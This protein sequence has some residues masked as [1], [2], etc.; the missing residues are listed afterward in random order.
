MSLAEDDHS[1]AR[2]REPYRV[3]N[4]GTAIADLGHLGSFWPG[5]AVGARERCSPDG[6]GILGA[7]V[8]VSDDENISAAGSDL[9]HQRP[10][11]PIPV[12]ATAEDG[13]QSALGDLTKG[14]QRCRDGIG[15]VRVID[16]GKKRL[17]GVDTFHPARYAWA[18]ADSGG[19]LL[20][21]DARGRQRDDREQRILE[22]V[23]A[24]HAHLNRH[25]HPARADCGQGTL[26][27]PQ[28]SVRPTPVSSPPARRRDG[29]NRDLGLGC[30][31]AAVVVVD[32]DHAMTSP[33]RSEQRPFGGEV[34]LHIAVEIEMVLAEVGEGSDVVQHAVDAAEGQ[35]VARDLHHG[36]SHAALAHHREERVQVC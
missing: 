31:P 29:H 3:G 16:H 22:V 19:R 11:S 17:A 20:D 13:N 10:L 12:A 24:G 26:A 28:D 25:A 32:V 8:V 33:L 21:R 14:G 5:D 9:P 2:S 6:P 18:G 15:G 36:G 27:R 4:R 23:T 7:R 1:V 30:Q 35:R 34:V